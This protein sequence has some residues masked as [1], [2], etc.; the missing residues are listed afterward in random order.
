MLYIFNKKGDLVSLD[1]VRELGIHGNDV[2][3]HWLKKN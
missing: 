1:G 3:D 2:Y